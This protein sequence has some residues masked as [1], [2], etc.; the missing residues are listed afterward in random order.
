MRKEK[1]IAAFKES[2]RY[3]SFCFPQLAWDYR[4]LTSLPEAKLKTPEDC[5]ALLALALCSYRV[6]PKLCA[7]LLSYLDEG[8]AQKHFEKVEEQLQNGK[9][10]K[11][12]SFF[13]GANPHNDYS[14]L[15]P[16]LFSV[17][18]NEESFYHPNEAKLYFI[19]SGALAP[20]SALFRQKS[21]GSWRLVKE[22]L[23]DE[24]VA[25]KQDNPWA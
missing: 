21:D 15:A 18:E 25:P 12:Y 2:P 6:S 24:I 14:P 9:D 13:E 10:Y 22:N 7:D 8:D 20:R 23:L 4:S 19:S 16:L 1:R 17:G 5:A 3:K 11:P